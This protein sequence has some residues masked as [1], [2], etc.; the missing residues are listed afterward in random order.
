MF[1]QGRQGG[2]GG[3]SMT[4]VYYKDVP[5]IFPLESHEH[6]NGLWPSLSLR[7]VLLMRL[8]K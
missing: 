3:I 1:E 5:G 8:S 6:E 2:E 4:H 7:L